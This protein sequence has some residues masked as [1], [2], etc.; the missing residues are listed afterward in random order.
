MARLQTSVFWF[1]LG[2]AVLVYGGLGMLMLLSPES[3]VRS[4]IVLEAPQAASAI[5]V[6]M[7][8][9][10][11]SLAVIAAF[12]IVR[13]EKALVCLTIVAVFSA[14]LVLTRLFSI[15]VDGATPHSLT[16]LRDEGLTTVF[17]LFALWC[18]WR[19]YSK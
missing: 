3:V 10:F 7:A 18:G 2:L 17:F 9:P 4:G 5:R 16:A 11:L 1:G 15:S 6:G 14:V 8:S 12:G 13:R 19:R